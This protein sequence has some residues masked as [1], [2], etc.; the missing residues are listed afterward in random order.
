MPQIRSAFKV[1][2]I[3]ILEKKS[4]F[5]A[6][7]FKIDTKSDTNSR[8]FFSIKSKVYNEICF[9][10]TVDVEKKDFEDAET[11]ILGLHK[12]ITAY[13]FNIIMNPGELF[14]EDNIIC[15]GED[16]VYNAFS[17][18]VER[19]WDD[20]KGLSVIK[21][22]E[23]YEENLEILN[24]QIGEVAEEYFS[25]EEAEKLKEDLKKLEQVLQQHIESTKLEE[26]EKDKEIRKLKEDI[27]L[28]QDTLVTFNKKNWISSFYARF[29][30][31]KLDPEKRKKIL[32]MGT[33]GLGRLIEAKTGD[34]TIKEILDEIN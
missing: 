6:E 5:Y 13:S 26:D 8:L 22:L 32:Q 10:F 31:M 20:F 1:K 16:A 11:N 9:E 19:A 15:N 27:S 17:D 33:K 34:S 21:R 4:G 29:S 30:P 23:K 14:A 12:K 24:E 18:W 3:S 7:D 2:L 25:I 28:L